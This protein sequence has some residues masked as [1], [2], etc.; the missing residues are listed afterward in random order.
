MAAKSADKEYD[1]DD[2]DDDEGSKDGLQTAEAE[3]QR[4]FNAFIC[5]KIDE[6][7]VSVIIVAI[8]SRPSVRLSVC[9]VEVPWSYTLG[10]S[11]VIT[12]ITSLGSS[13]LRAPTSAI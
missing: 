12:Q 3:E 1:A 2:E 13:L 11:K 4:Q 5:S 8:V 9:D 6:T 7:W 10:T